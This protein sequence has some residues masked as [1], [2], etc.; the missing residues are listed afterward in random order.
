MY[1]KSGDNYCLITLNGRLLHTQ[2]N[3]IIN[4]NIKVRLL[5][6]TELNRIEG[7]LSAGMDDFD[8]N[9]EIFQCCFLGVIGFDGDTIDL[10]ESPAFLIDSISEYI[11]RESKKIL[12]NSIDT[13]EECLSTVNLFQMMAAKVSQYMNVKYEE[14]I[15]YPVDKLIMYYSILHRTYPNDVMPIVTPEG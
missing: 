7:M 4:P 15:S 12:F 3:T 5:N 10:Y 8:I 13:F 14:A 9:E 1:L 11:Y 6:V 2:N